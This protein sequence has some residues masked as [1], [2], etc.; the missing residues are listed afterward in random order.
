MVQ[1]HVAAPWAEPLSLLLL[2]PQQEGREGCMFHSS[3]RA[4]QKL[5]SQVLCSSISP[6]GR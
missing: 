2:E 1:T 4:L 6:G 5:L 3:S